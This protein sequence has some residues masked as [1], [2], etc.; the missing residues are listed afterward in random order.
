MP[1]RLSSTDPYPLL[2]LTGGE[3]TGMRVETTVWFKGHAKELQSLEISA[4]RIEGT[5][6]LLYFT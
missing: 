6:Q 2:L 4:E 5:G 1:G 3:E